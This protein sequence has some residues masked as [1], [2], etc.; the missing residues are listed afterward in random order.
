MSFIA[1]DWEGSYEYCGLEGCL[2]VDDILCE[3]VV[4]KEVMRE[5]V[6][7]YG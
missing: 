2:A 3:W 1:G 6:F 5:R 4:S 7:G